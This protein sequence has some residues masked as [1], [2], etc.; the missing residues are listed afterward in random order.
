MNDTE[1]YVSIKLP[2]IYWEI[3]DDYNSFSGRKYV[4]VSELKN[5]KAVFMDLPVEDIK[6][7]AVN[8]NMNRVVQVLNKK[9]DILIGTQMIV[10]GPHL[11]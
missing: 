1:F 11:D 7:M 8:E 5:T 6:V 3:N 2:V 4:H 10:K 9:A